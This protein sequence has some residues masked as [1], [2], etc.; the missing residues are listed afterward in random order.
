MSFNDEPSLNVFQRLIRQFDEIHPYNAAQ[1][2]RLR[3]QPEITSID[4]AWAETL[5][6]LRI[7]PI[8]VIAKRFEEPSAGEV[9]RDVK[10]LDPLTGDLAEHITR[11]LNRPFNPNG[12]DPFRPFVLKEDQ[13]SYWA[14]VVYQHIVADSVSIRML[15]REWFL[16]MF[17]PGAARR[18]PLKIA[19]R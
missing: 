11:A 8:R 5:H 3:G 18:E 4:R 9:L 7:G 10:M 15:L 19:T 17:D 2:M 14:G 16:R 12:R 6:D 1:I 13:E